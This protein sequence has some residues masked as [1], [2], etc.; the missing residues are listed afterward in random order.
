MLIIVCDKALTIVDLFDGI[1]GN[2]ENHRP[3]D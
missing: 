2:I 1:F 3:K